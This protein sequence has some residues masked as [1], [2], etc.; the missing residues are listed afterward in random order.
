VIGFFT[1]DGVVAPHPPIIEHLHKAR[2]ALVAAGHEVIDWA[3]V[4]HMLAF[5]LMVSQSRT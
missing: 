4:G 2:D 1:H 3:P 5:E